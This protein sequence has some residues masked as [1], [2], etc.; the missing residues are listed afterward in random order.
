MKTKALHIA[1]DLGFN[2]KL[3]SELRDHNENAKKKYEEAQDNHR[4]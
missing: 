4:A 2:T 3:C 1:V